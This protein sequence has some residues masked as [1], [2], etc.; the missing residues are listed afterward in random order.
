MHCI[1]WE[2]ALEAEVLRVSFGYFEHYLITFLV[3]FLFPLVLEDIHNL[4]SW[5][6]IHDMFRVRW[7]ILGKSRQ[8]HEIMVVLI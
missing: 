1:F 3:H 4:L 7:L 2:S 8:L 5:I 6:Y